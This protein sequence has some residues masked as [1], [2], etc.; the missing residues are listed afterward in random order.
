MYST[1]VYRIKVSS[2]YSSSIHYGNKSLCYSNISCK[3]DIRFLKYDVNLGSQQWIIIQ[4]S[5][6]LL[7]EYVTRDSTSKQKQ[8]KF[9]TDDKLRLLELLSALY[10]HKRNP[11]SLLNNILKTGASFLLTPLLDWKMEDDM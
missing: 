6:F 7:F 3:I 9:F 1:Q 5:A 11:V 4:K 8:E 10:C 2:F